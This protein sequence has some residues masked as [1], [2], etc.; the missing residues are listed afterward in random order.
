MA[1][2]LLISVVTTYPSLICPRG[3]GF[4]QSPSTFGAK[5]LPRLTSFAAFDRPGLQA[6]GD[7]RHRMKNYCKRASQPRRTTIL[8]LAADQIGRSCEIE[9]GGDAKKRP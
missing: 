8:W 3:G 7:F 1:L 4:R 2:F 9:N 6:C 5:I